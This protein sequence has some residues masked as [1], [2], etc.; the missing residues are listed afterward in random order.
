MA[1]AWVLTRCADWQSL[2]SRPTWQRLMD[3]TGLR[4]STVAKY[5]RLLRDAGLLGI[6]ESGTTP[7]FRSFLHADDGNRASVYVLCVLAH[8]QVSSVEETRTPTS[9]PKESWST[10]PHAREELGEN[11]APTR[12]VQRQAP[13]LSEISDRH[14]RSV[15]RPYWDAGWTVSDVLWCLDHTP[16]GELWPHTDRVRHVPGWARYRLAPWAGLASP[17]QQRAAWHEVLLAEQAARRAECAS[18]RAAAATP[19]TLRQHAA[20]ARELLRTRSPAAARILDR[21]ALGQAS[22]RRMTG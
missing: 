10:P 11:L 7:Q 3:I 20:M 18:V 6:V 14:L 15:L 22:L 4:R 12:E 16:S 1:V 5:L 13:V 9:S 19:D 2:T 21:R 17:S 8:A